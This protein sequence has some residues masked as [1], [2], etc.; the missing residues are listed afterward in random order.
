M[1]FIGCD[2]GSDCSGDYCLI[3][4]VPVFFF[5]V[6]C[7]HGMQRDEEFMFDAVTV[8][9]MERVV[10]DALEWRVR[11]V[12]PLAFLGFFLSACYPP[13]QHPLQVAAVKARAVDILLRAQPGTCAADALPCQCHGIASKTKRKSTT[14]LP[15]VLLYSYCCAFC[16][17]QRSR[18]RSSPP[19]W[20]P[21]LRCSPPPERSPPRTC[22]R[23]KPASPPA[24]L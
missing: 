2:L 5:P 16:I 3:S 4:S 12:T 10:L 18:W 9:R 11:S 6:F 19:P 22:P 17:L 14:L 20:R 24:P 21:R 13:P 23:S 7:C 1:V 15:S 8:R